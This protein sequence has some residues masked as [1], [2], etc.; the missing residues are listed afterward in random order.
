MRYIF[1]PKAYNALGTATS[2][3]IESWAEFN[4]NVYAFH[5]DGKSKII[6]KKSP[7]IGSLRMVYNRLNEPVLSQDDDE[8]AKNNTW[9][10]VQ[11][12]G[13]GRSVRSGQMQLPA[14][15][16]RE[17]LQTLFDSFTDAKQFEER[18]TIQTTSFRKYTNRSFPLALRTYIND[19]TWKKIHYFDD[20]NFRYNDSY[21]GSISAYGFQTNPYN[22][23]AYSV[24]NAKGLITGG[25]HKIDN[26]G[27][28]AFPSSV[29]YDDKNRPLQSIVYQDLYARNQSDTKY[30]FVGE[31]LINQM[32]YRKN[33]DLDRIRTT[34]NILDHSGRTKEIYYTLKEGTVDKVPR[35]KMCSLFFDNI[36]RL[37]TKMVQ[38]NAN[39]ISSLQSGTWTTANIWTN[40]T[41]PSL[42]TPAVINF[43]HTVT[44]PANTTVQ[45]GTLYDAGKLTFLTNAKL[46]MGSLAPVKGAALQVIEYSYN[47][48]GQLRGVNL[49]A[50][51]NPQVSQDKLFSYKIDYHEDG[52]LFNGSISK[53][54][55]K[56]QNSPQNRNYTYTYDRS[57]KL[58]NAQFSGVGAENY[59][60]STDYDVNGNIQHLQR[61]S[62]TGTNTYGLVDN[63]TY[64]YTGTGN[65]LQKV[66]DAVTGNA[67]ANDFR[68]V[69]G[70]D[71]TF[72]ADGKIT[73][74][75][76]KSIF[77][78]KYNFLDLV[79]KVTFNDSTKVEFFYTSTGERRQRKVTKN[80]VTS[81]TLYDGEM[82]YQF[83]GNV[84]SLNDFKVS[85]I[86]NGEGRFVNGKLEYAYTDHIGNL[87]LSYKDSSGVAFITQSQSYDPW[88]NINAGSEYQ[89]A[90]IQGD[91]YFVSGQETDNITGNILLDWRHY[92]SVTGRMNS[93][94]PEDPYENISGFSYSL[95]NPVSTIDPDGRNPV[96]L[97]AFIIGGG[98]NVATNWSKL[99]GG[100]KGAGQAIGYFVSG[101]VG[102]VVSLT[103]PLGGGAITSAANATIDIVTGN[104]PD[105]KSPED[106]LLYVG[107]EA[108]YGAA[109]S[110]AGAQAG[111]IIGPAL[112]KLGN[113][114]GGWFKN[115]FQAYA[116]ESLQTVL[117]DGKPITTT[118]DVGIKATKTYVAKALGGSLGKT[119]ANAESN[120][121][122]PNQIHFMQS[123]IKNSTG[124]FTVLGNA[125][126]LSQGMLD[127]KK[128]TMNVWKDAEGKIWTLDHRRLAAF[129]FSGLDKAPVNWADPTGQMWKMTTKTGGSS[130]WL[131]LGNGT[132]ITIK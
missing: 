39:A 115:S 70:N 96:I 132:G 49:D 50:S 2:L 5:Y 71:Y 86:Q 108:A 68:D 15:Y 10:Y 72:S 18:D 113:S 99:G 43:G 63:L 37:K 8:L 112:S 34:E 102:G 130:I 84:T 11:T 105:F 73:K 65:K 24:T 69:V 104:V 75:N 101:G 57:N 38:P 23:T 60:V 74:D 85:E 36:G 52:R 21:S 95:N 54:S 28:F 126:D 32:I 20:Y 30:N 120:V 128:L 131:K 110:F 78:I 91:R 17:A 117:I 124:E 53:F 123:S 83:T 40:N 14:T 118:I 111:K 97:V 109:T 29:F 76:N 103:N 93:Y 56:S 4:E 62:K 48:L 9:N 79:S 41:I 6:E 66:D 58:T 87:R 35:L 1:P 129:K 7:G 44:I 19:A 100:W 26:F 22:S 59:S 25:L 121:L 13:Q 67:I 33:G 55:W 107:K 90:G 125:R 82:I 98:L 116:R 51:G 80:G 16:T 127:P 3:N 122:N 106:A 92:D 61:Y 27:D 114:I 42:T 45:A 81:Y 64:S 31:S 94:D 47:V 88:S 12:D 77:N 89:L 119:L 46:Q